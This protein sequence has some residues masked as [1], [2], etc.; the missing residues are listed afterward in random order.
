MLMREN[1]NV[2][3]KWVRNQSEKGRENNQ[4]KTQTCEYEMRKQEREYERELSIE[5]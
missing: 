4:K 5:T 1:K 2:R 3:K